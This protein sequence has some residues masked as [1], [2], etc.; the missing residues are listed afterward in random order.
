MSS[1]PYAPQPQS[2]PL[3]RQSLSDGGRPQVVLWFKVYAAILALVYLGATLV[4]FGLL[5][6]DRSDPDMPEIV[7]L[8]LLLLLGGTSLVCLGVF[9]AAIFL[10]PKPWVWI[11]DLV[12]ICLGFT[13]VCSMPFCIPLLIFWL[14]PE[15][16]RQFGRSA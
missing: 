4:S 2:P 9:A 8:F 13:S 15:T 3:E 14:K 1:N 11:Y 12:L 7:S 10:Q 6:V 16:K 5:F